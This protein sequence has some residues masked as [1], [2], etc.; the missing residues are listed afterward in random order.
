MKIAFFSTMTGMPWG[1]SEELWSRAASALLARGH[2]VC[3]SY[4]RRPQT[5]AKLLGLESEGAK[6]QLRSGFHWGRSVRRMLERLG[7]GNRALKKWLHQ[8]RPDFVVVSLGYHTDDPTIT[9]AW[10]ARTSGSSGSS[11]NRNTTPTPAPRSASSS[12]R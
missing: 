11:G 12:R 10:R 1:G 7:V 2:E 5:P 9:A 6:V 8:T 4:R 3:V